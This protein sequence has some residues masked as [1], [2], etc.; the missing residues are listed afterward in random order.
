MRALRNWRARKAWAE[1]LAAPPARPREPFRWGKGARILVLADRDA[2]DTVR[3][4]QV[5]V[6]AQ[7]RRGAQV[8]S[9]WWTAAK[10]PP[11]QRSDDIWGPHALDFSELPRPEA[12]KPY[13]RHGYDLVVHAGLAPFA[14]FDYL[15]GGLQ[16]H[17]RVAG[18]ADAP[19]SY[20]LIVGL[21]PG[22]GVAELLQ[23]TVR[24]IELIRPEYA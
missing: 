22:A 7:T 3:A 13:R 2:P 24:L 16:A 1:R 8:Q 12:E 14:P 23:E 19:A 4:V 15:V 5:L 18:Y 6:E 11:E 17:R 20:D 21:K 9:L 10:L